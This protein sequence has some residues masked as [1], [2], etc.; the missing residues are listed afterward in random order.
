MTLIYEP[1]L[2][3]RK[4]YLHGPTERYVSRSRLSKVREQTGQMHTA[5]VNECITTPY[6]DSPLFTCRPTVTVHTVTHV[7]K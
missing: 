4:I 6:A 7:D 5:D 2:D 1:D 3:I